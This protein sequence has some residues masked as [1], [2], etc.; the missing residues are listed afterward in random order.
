M[1]TAGWIAKKSNV[2]EKREVVRSRALGLALWLTASVVFYL[3]V[4][5][6]SASSRS[7]I[8]TVQHVADGDSVT[9]ISDNGTK[10]RIRLLGIE[11]PEVAHNRK[12]GQPFGEEARDYLDHL[13][14]GKMIRVD[15]YGPDQYKRVLG[16]IWDDQVNVN[17]RTVAMGYAE[18]YRGAPCHAY[19]RKLE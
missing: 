12:S 1:T 15:A 16:V 10:L 7:L 6:R 9:A 2:P 19:C 3:A 5:A 11:A 18:V 13:I 4:P 17:L 14:G 8:A